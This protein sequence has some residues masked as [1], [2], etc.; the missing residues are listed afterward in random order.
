MSRLSSRRPRLYRTGLEVH[1]SYAVMA[2]VSSIPCRRSVYPRAWLH[3]RLGVYPLRAALGATVEAEARAER[4][5]LENDAA[6]RNDCCCCCCCCSRLL[7]LLY[8][9][10]NEFSSFT[11]TASLV[12]NANC[13]YNTVRLPR[14]SIRHS[15]VGSRAKANFILRLWKM[16]EEER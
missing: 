16:I 10:R 6:R 13:V 15:A 8:T 11:W 7:L 4:F 9:R 2:R 1:A 14:M 12:F 5:P 3:G